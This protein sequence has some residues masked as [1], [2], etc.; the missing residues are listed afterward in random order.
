M[1]PPRIDASTLAPAD[2]SVYCTPPNSSTHLD[3]HHHT[4]PYFY[5]ADFPTHSLVEVQFQ[6]RLSA[7]K[8]WGMGAQ[9]P[10]E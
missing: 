8:Y 5:S 10:K 6:H 3:S 2:Q 7:G 9:L 1:S 4:Q